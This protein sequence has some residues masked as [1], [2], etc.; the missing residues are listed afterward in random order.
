MG[1]KRSSGMGNRVAVQPAG[2]R[3]KPP[4]A[5]AGNRSFQRDIRLLLWALRGVLREHG[6]GDLEAF[7]TSLRQLARQRRDGDPAAAATIGQWLAQRSTEELHQLIRVQGCRLELLNLAEDCNRIRVLRDRE[8]AAYPAPREESIGAAIDSLCRD[9]WPAPRVQELLDRLEICPVFTAHPTE[10]KRI[11]VRRALAR[12]RKAL[13]ELDEKQLLRRERHDLLSRIRSDLMCFWETETVRPRRPSVLDEVGRNLVVAETLWEVAPRLV[14]D[15]RAALRRNFAAR[16][17]RIGRFLRFATWIGGDRDGNPYVTSTVTRQTMEVL[18]SDT[19]RRHVEACHEL[20][21]LLSV[22]ARYHPI[23][24]ALAEAILAARRRWPEAERA[25]AT[26]HP[27]ELYR[28]WLVIIRRRLEATAAVAVSSPPAEMSYRSSDELLE[29]LD[30]IAANLRE[31]GHRALAEGPLQEWRDRI[32]VLGF[33]TVELDVRD[34]SSSLNSAVQEIAA[35]TGLCAD[36]AALSEHDKQQFLLKEPEPRALGAAEHDALSPGAREVLDLFRL[37]AR[38]AARFGHKSLGALIVSMTHR[39]S[40]V[41]TMLWLNRLGAALEGVACSPLPI[42]PLFETI[43]DLTRADQILVEML[44]QPQYLAYLEAQGRNQLCMIGYSDSVKDGGYLAANWQL[45]DA[46]RRLAALSSRFG[47]TVSFFHGRGGA[48]GRGG[49]PAARAVVS[50]PPGSVGGRL[51]I[52]EQG[53]VVADRYGDPIIAHRHLEQL[54]WATLH[55]SSQNEEPSRQAWSSLLSRAAVAG[56]A[57]YRQLLADP[58]FEAYFYAATPIEVIES[59]PIGSRPSRR[60]GQATLERLRAI[61]YT[62]AWTQ[63]RHMLTGFYGLGSG[64]AAVA[65]SDWS[66]L[67]QMYRQW[68]FFRALV[69]NAE[70]AVAKAEPSL[71]RQ[72]ASIV[73]DQ[74]AAERIRRRIEAEIKATREAILRI[75][76]EPSLLAGTPWLERSIAMRNPDVDLVNFIQIELLRRQRRA[77]DDPAVA[78]DN[79]LAGEVLRSSVHALSAGLRTTG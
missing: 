8:A 55:V 67:A 30:L 44:S 20:E 2:L 17:F 41:L 27:Q 5:V 42:V 58:G 26:H 47:V 33:H 52:T 36:F 37:L 4:A 11:T 7:A 45:Y 23:G 10:A 35:A 76:G 57:A 74:A 60:D 40:D 13:R 12:M 63:S 59:L 68:S 19:L 75:T 14:R 25:V 54:T 6:S 18:R 48:L 32:A 3:A 43:A 61:P 38:T 72:Y 66:P 29:D 15:L 73:P 9:H 69:D 21:S 51:R 34:D 1:S 71:V 53:E 65:G 50:L 78:A 56:N 24:R 77:G 64:L 62:F 28:H 70:L 31:S 46:Q 39:P 22:S 49:G 16:E 79:E